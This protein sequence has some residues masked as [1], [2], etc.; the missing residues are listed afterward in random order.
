MSA[1]LFPSADTIRRFCVA[2]ML[3]PC[4][5]AQFTEFP[6]LEDGLDRTVCERY[7]KEYYYERFHNMNLEDSASAHLSSGGEAAAP[8]AMPAAVAAAASSASSS[9]AA[10]ASSG[11]SSAAVAASVPLATG[12]VTEGSVIAMGSTNR[13]R[14]LLRRAQTTRAPALQQA[15]SFADQMGYVNTPAAVRDEAVEYLSDQVPATQRRLGFD[16]KELLK[17]IHDNESRFPKIT[18]MAMEVLAMPPTTAGPERRF[19]KVGKSREKYQRRTKE[20]TLQVH[21]NVAVNWSLVES[22]RTLP[23]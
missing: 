16:G 17:H 2:S 7:F 14:A 22:A 21:T 10:A 11:S 15:L 6:P 3:A 4:F 5:K 19:S 20:S 1:L 13:P 8:T 23:Q 18:R 9:A 12:S